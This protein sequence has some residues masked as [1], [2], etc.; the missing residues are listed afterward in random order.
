MLGYILATA[1]TL[2]PRRTTRLQRLLNFLEIPLPDTPV[3]EVLENAPRTLAIEILTRRV[4]PATCPY[5]AM[6][7]KHE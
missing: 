5:P 4:I 3:W 1:V 6:E 2:P 7:E